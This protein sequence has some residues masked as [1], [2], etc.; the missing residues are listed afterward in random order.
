MV[1]VTPLIHLLF[2]LHTYFQHIKRQEGLEK[3]FIPGKRKSK[4]SKRRWVQDITD[5]LQMSTSDAGHL[6]YDQAVFRTA[7][8]VAKFGQG[9]ATE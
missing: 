5:E 2:S 9:H 3:R 1:Y 7:V 6:V 4:Q 8:K